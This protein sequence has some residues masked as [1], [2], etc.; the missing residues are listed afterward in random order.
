[1]PSLSIILDIHVSLLAITPITISQ[2]L[3]NP[4][5]N[6]SGTS[7]T[8]TPFS[9][10]SFASSVIF[11]TTCFTVILSSF[12]FFILSLKTISASFFLSSSKSSFRISSPNS[13]TISS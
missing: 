11:G 9:S 12:S 1:M 8:E 7:I 2:I 3:S 13:L 5:S 4:D 10:F 6:R